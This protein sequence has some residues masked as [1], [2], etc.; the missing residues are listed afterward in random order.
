[1]SKYEN[2]LKTIQQQYLVLLQEFSSFDTK[3]NDFYYRAISL[4]DRCESFWLAKRLQVIEILDALAQKE[5]C[6]LLSGAIYLG[7]SNNSHYEFG[8]IG[9]RKIINDP[10]LR[11][12]NFFCCSEDE[13]TEELKKYFFEAV[14]DTIAVLENY[15]ECFIILSVD[16]LFGEDRDENRSLGEKIYWDVISN[17]LNRDIRSLDAIKSE[18][19]SIEDLEVALGDTGKKF[20]FCDLTDMNLP[21][22]DRINN[23]FSENG[24]MM[25]LNITNEMDRFFIA[26]MSQIQ[27]AI[28][29]I[30]KCVRFNLYPFIRFGVSIQYFIMIAG[31]Y[32]DDESLRIRIE[33]SLISYL[34]AN[35]VVPEKICNV[36]FNVYFQLCKG[37]DLYGALHNAVFIDKESFLSFDMNQAVQIMRN[38]YQS[39]ILEEL[40]M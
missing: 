36:D 6:S 40:K 2:D 33:Y 4:I 38:I 30:I 20:I 18:Y 12:K 11:M 24:N 25:K 3:Q 32:A 31:A 19:T 29:I 8:T 37:K 5:Q 39:L 27:Q 1:M 28:D 9:D 26:T 13:V 23:W 15:S 16:S 34:L 22:K 35:Y 17:V 21:L 7:V 10:V 14:I